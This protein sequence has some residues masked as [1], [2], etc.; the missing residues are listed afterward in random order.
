MR[1]TS[2]IG[3]RVLAAWAVAS[4]FFLYGF[5]H[6]VSPSVMVEELMRDFA[7]GAAVLGNLSAF[8]FYAYAGLQIPVGL[9]MDRIGARRLTTAAAAL[10]A[11]GSGLFAISDTVAL[12]SVGRALIGA[13]AGFSF[14]GALTIATQLLPPQRFAQFGGLTQAAGMTG[15]V[16][17][18]A[19][20]AAVV[21][22]IGWRP[23]ILALGGLGAALAAALWL[24]VPDRPRPATS[25]RLMDGLRQVLV[26]PQSW[27]NAGF[28]L[29]MTGPMLAFAGLWGVP[30]LVTVYGMERPAA[31]AMLS[32]MFIGWG[33]G[34][35]I[36]G[37][38]SDR[39]GRR[40]PFMAACA[41]AAA[42][43]LTVILYVPDLPLAALSAL[44][45]AHGAAG[46]AM[47]LGFACV[48]ENNSPDAA[49]AAYGF[50]NTA[51]VGSGA[52]FQPL[53]GFLLDMSWDGTVAAGVRLYST[54]A[55]Q[56]ACAVLPMGCAIGA[57]AA[58]IG[59]ETYAQQ[60]VSL[61]RPLA[62]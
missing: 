36:L 42:A 48:R 7:V 3:G 14:L 8:Y 5:I 4:L 34:C 15:A 19:P 17:A 29:A 21:A 23:T 25:P 16:F 40:K 57:V 49:A 52:L 58:L 1:E 60:Q 13:G 12:A 44:M 28:G 31:A 24:L 46:S 26:N 33:V 53:I 59:R 61:A 35:P 22:E 38:V 10:C 39:V 47:I 18:Q 27:L 50:T 51:V 41:A 54:D 6:R 32:L 43:T 37:F 56:F 62:A 9:L 55:Y 20:L 30:W 2:G 45:I 11:L